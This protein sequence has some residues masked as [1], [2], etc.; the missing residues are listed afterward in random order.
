MSTTNVEK[1]NNTGLEKQNSIMD[2]VKT[3]FRWKVALLMWGA[4]AIN[5]FDRTNL[6]A[7]APMIMK[8]FNFTATE[9][10]FIMSAFFFSYTLFQIP[11][12]WLADKFGQR[13]VLGGAVGWWSAATMSIALCQGFVSF[14]AARILLGIGEAGAY[15][16]NAGIVSKWFP[17]KERAR[18]TVI[19]D[20]GN[21]CGT[22]FAMPIIVWMMLNFGWKVPF[23]ISGLLGFLWCLLWFKYY[24][25]PEKSKYANQAEIDYIRNGQTN[26]D[27][28]GNTEQPLKWY[29]L[30]RYRN[31]RAMCIG[32]FMSNY[33]I[34]FYITWFP[35][36]LV[37]ARG[38]SLMKMGFVAMIPPLIGLCVGF[39]SAYFADYLYSKGYS[40]TRVRKNN[41]VFGMLLASSIV[42]V[43]FIQTDIGA[44][45]LLT[46]SYCGIACAGPAL[47][48][49]PGD[50]APCNMTST[51]GALQNCV[52]NIGG[53][54]GPIVTG[55]IVATTGS[56]QMAMMVTGCAT[57][58]GAL[59]YAFYLGE[60]KNIEV[61]EISTSN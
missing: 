33:A 20:S 7:A 23:I 16:A 49:L 42:F 22:A 52:S 4:I 36:Y 28:V 51:V 34:Y 3:G 44:V 14:I 60:V 30:L 17:D 24:T 6:S 15:P 57:L 43:N 32:F 54:L 47:W 55:W 12:G 21:K 1:D 41:L 39:L 48:T 27:G 40:K 35:T 10:G 56:F 29:E 38:M 5:Y 59:N 53:I 11:S 2:E 25:D 13:L 58:I 19:F 26:K 61:D 9:M 31:I 37:K 45:A 8:E 50:V 46:L 18:A